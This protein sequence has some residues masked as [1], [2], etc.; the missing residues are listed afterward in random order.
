MCLLDIIEMIDPA[1]S[2]F[3]AVTAL[4]NQMS[5]PTNQHPLGASRVSPHQNQSQ[6][7]NPNPRTN[8]RTPDPPNYQSKERV[9][10]SRARKALTAHI[11]L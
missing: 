8:E 7:A 9:E 3:V 11:P 4:T 6:P 2:Q 1:L 5:P 10:C